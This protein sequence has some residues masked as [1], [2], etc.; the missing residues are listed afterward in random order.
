M[1]LVF[2]RPTATRQRTRRLRD[3][4]RHRTESSRSS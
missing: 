3:G 2:T 4:S 1:S